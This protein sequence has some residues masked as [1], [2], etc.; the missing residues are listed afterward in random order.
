M[1][2]LL[3]EVF[4]VKIYSYGVMVALAF[5]LGFA[6]IAKRAQAAGE[7]LDD[8]TEALIWFI[9]SGIGGAR[10]FYFIWF[11]HVFLKNPL[12]ALLNQ[13]GLV[14]YGGVIGVLMATITYTRLKKIS[15]LRFGD[16]VAPAAVLGLAIGRIGCLLSGCCYGAPCSLPWAIRYPHTHET[17]GLPVH[18]A[19]LYETALMLIACWWLTR[20]DKTKPFE[21]F[22]LAWFFIL[23]GITRFSLEFVRG[24]KLVWTHAMELS[25]SQWVSIAGILAGLGMI[26]YLSATTPKRKLASPSPES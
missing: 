21:G 17:L 20:L 3:F 13:G 8:Y 25:A 22:T 18:P 9:I 12:G 16:I 5:L 15:L 7:K 14:W 11:P 4:G 10:L 6:L 23:A 26:A 24:D 1:H 2:P 19:P